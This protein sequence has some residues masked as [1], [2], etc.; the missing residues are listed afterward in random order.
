MAF[1]GLRALRRRFIPPRMATDGSSFSIS[2]IWRCGAYIICLLAKRTLCKPSFITLLPL[3]EPVDRLT[4]DRPGV[5]S[6]VL[7]E[8]VN[9]WSGGYPKFGAWE[10]LEL[11]GSKLTS[12]SFSTTYLA[13]R[14][15]SCTSYPDMCFSALVTD[16]SLL[17]AFCFPLWEV[18]DQDT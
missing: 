16:S 3:A 14:Y 9:L 4:W 1:G 6:Q 17:T 5:V 12:E 7:M 10:A 2:R 15:R 13:W 11:T 8:C 18:I